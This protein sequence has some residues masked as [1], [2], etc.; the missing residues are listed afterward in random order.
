MRNMVSHISPFSFTFTGE[1]GMRE[2]SVIGVLQRRLASEKNT[3]NDSFEMKLN[4]T[5]TPSK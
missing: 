1:K 3:D 5:M 4:S 2:E